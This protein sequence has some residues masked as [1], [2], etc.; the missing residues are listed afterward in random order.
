MRFFIA[1]VA[2]SLVGIVAG[3]MDPA[4]DQA[5]DW[6]RQAA[7]MTRT[8]IEALL[9]LHIEGAGEVMRFDSNYR[10]L[11]Y[12]LHSPQV[13][14][15][16]A[17]LAVPLEGWNPSTLDD[18]DASEFVYNGRMSDLVRDCSES[19]LRCSVLEK[20]LE[21]SRVAEALFRRYGVAR[22][23]IDTANSLLSKVHLPSMTEEELKTLKIMSVSEIFHS[24]P[25]SP[26]EETAAVGSG[27]S[28][29]RVI[30]RLGLSPTAAAVPLI[31]DGLSSV[32]SA[33]Q[34]LARIGIDRV[35][36]DATELEI[37]HGAPIMDVH[38][39]LTGSAAPHPHDG[40]RAVQL[41]LDRPM[42]H[43]PAEPVRLD[44]P[45]SLDLS[46]LVNPSE[47]GEA[48][49]VADWI[50]ARHPTREQEAT[51]ES[52]AVMIFSPTVRDC[53]KGECGRLRSLL[54]NSSPWVQAM[55]L[56]YVIGA[57]VRDETARILL[58]GAGFVVGDGSLIVAAAFRRLTLATIHALLT[59][60]GASRSGIQRLLETRTVTLNSEY[61]MYGLK[62]SAGMIWQATMTATGGN[63]SSSESTPLADTASA[64]EVYRGIFS[65]LVS[66]CIASVISG[67]CGPLFRRIH[68]RPVAMA[69]VIY[70]GALNLPTGRASLLMTLLS[71]RPTF[72]SPAAALR[73]RGKSLAGVITAMKDLPL[74]VAVNTVLDSV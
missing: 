12:G 35:V 49:A 10:I 43:F 11:E 51:G 19:S 22:L 34:L 2:I 45:L 28:G 13:Q 31:N 57:V 37:L 58:Q 7:K 71:G 54:L 74:D 15:L 73:L 50:L 29:A 33:D 26:F 23:S 60:D 46:A 32:E 39:L 17:M 9:R 55:F 24:L 25:P 4:W 53:L 21:K 41:A 67:N 6:R 38:A 30:R 1:S 52:V 8:N 61:P 47:P 68:M 70:F 72:V 56:R 65:G 64:A 16:F 63:I 20:R 3:S 44:D 40:V 36:T 59:E 27:R 42:W 14:I 48:V 62:S 66:E 69:L 5:R 18:A